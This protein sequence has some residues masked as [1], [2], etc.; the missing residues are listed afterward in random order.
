MYFKD[1]S[2]TVNSLYSQIT[3]DPNNTVLLNEHVSLHWALYI[4][5]T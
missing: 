5:V 4:L 2:N 1:Y 3:I